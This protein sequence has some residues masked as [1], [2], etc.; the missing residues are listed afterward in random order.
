MS[1]SITIANLHVENL[2]FAVDGVQNLTDPCPPFAKVP[3]SA[4]SVTFG[5]PS[6]GEHIWVIPAP[7]RICAFVDE[8]EGYA[9]VRALV[10]TTDPGSAAVTYDA[11]SVQGRTYN[12][13]RWE[14]NAENLVPG[15][16]YSAAG[17][18][19]YL[20]IWHR[21]GGATDFT[22]GGSV[23]FWGHTGSATA[24]CGGSGTPTGT[25]SGSGPASGS[26]GTASCFAR[27]LAATLMATLGGG[28][29]TV[30]LVWNSVDLW[31]GSK[32][33]AC[34]IT[35][36]LRFS[37]ACTLQYSCD[38][39]TWFAAMPPATAPV[40]GAPMRT[41]DYTG[42]NLNAGASGCTAAGG[43]TIAASIGE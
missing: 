31:Q 12:T 38:S 5:K 1:N 43:G 19:N 15:A 24:L 32:A 22:Y 8:P 7:G 4:R 17:S 37:T 28:N 41:S 2:Y 18:Q 11:G 27:P 20:L 30:P 6:T 16:A 21:L 14:W 3:K 34:G 25:P 42:I 10:T 29:G 26:G 13:R 36:R 35:L 33:L 39:I 9:E 23:A 40:S